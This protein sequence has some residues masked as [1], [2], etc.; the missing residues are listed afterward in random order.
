[1]RGRASP[2]EKMMIIL[3][4]ISSLPHFQT[5]HAGVFQSRSTN[6]S[7]VIRPRE[8]P[9]LAWVGS[10]TPLFPLVYRNRGETT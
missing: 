1:M 8:L 2:M 9:I 6:A 4:S 7:L 5:V 3:V 10:P